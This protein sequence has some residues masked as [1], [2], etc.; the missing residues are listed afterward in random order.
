MKS[1]WSY[2]LSV[3]CLLV[4]LTACSQEESSTVYVVAI[5]TRWTPA[6]T[7][8]KRININNALNEF[9][10][11]VEE[12]HHIV[13]QRD[14]IGQEQALHKLMKKSID[15]A[16]LAR[17]NDMP[18][19]G[20]LESSELFLPLS[21]VLIVPFSTQVDRLDQMDNTLIGVQLG[22]VGAKLLNTMPGIFSKYYEHIKLGLEDT[23]AGRIEG[24]LLG[25]LLA[26]GY[27]DSLYKGRLKI[28]GKPLSN[29]GIRLFRMQKGS[30]RS[31]IFLDIINTEI[32]EMRNDD[33]L[34]DLFEKWGVYQKEG[35]NE[36]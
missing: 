30:K 19:Y 6:D 8:G 9:L 34:L 33:L 28:V 26:K 31:K 10:D 14:F 5:D 15:G 13:I 2:F 20:I 16:F 11:K 12:K 35:L 18:P 1:I 17:P 7:Q 29:E 21:F 3:F 36:N 4:G 22:S 27:C 23:V 32:R 24:L 25:N